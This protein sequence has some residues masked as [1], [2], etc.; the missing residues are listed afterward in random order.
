MKIYAIADLHLSFEDFVEP[1][2]WEEVKEYKSMEIFGEKWRMHYK[3][4]YENCLDI[5]TEN[6]LLLIPGDISWA[7][8]LKEMEADIDFIRKLPGKKIFIKGNHDY[9]WKGVNSLRTALP[10][11][12]Y[13][14][15]ND[16]LIFNGVALAGSRAW[17]V[18]NTYQFSEKDKKIFNRE[19][20]RLELSLK[21]IQKAEKIIVMLHYM[22]TN[23]QHEHNQLIALL[24][25]YNVDICIYGHL[26][27]DESHEIRLEGQKW[28]IE[29]NLVSSDFIDFKPR[30]IFPK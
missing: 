26:H 5:V 20:I 18:P 28:G 6:D 13:L 9:W 14:I 3:K 15:Q 1:A 24:E 10:D 12:F 8:N 7:T 30:L 4:I 21:S 11:D 23:E 29:F 2:N 17:T 22:P 19:L 25:K 16:S 27:G